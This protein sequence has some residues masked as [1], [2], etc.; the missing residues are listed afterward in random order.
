MQVADS[1]VTGQN[2]FTVNLVHDSLV[3]DTV[4]TAVPVTR[5]P[6]ISHF[7]QS[8]AVLFKIIER[9]TDYSDQ[10]TVFIITLTLM[11]TLIWYFFPER[12]Y[13]LLSK[14][15]SKH[16]AK[17]SDNQFAKPGILL[18]TLYVLTIVSTI[19]FFI[20]FI[21][22][23]LFPDY[24]PHRTFYET[25]ASISVVVFLYFT[26]RVIIIYGAGVLFNTLEPA[27]QQA[28]T[29]FR[30]DLIISFM[31]IPVILLASS[32]SYSS[33]SYAG[34]ILMAGAILLKWVLS[35]KTG[36][37]SSKISLY[38]NILYLCALEIV[39]VIVLIKLIENY[40]IIF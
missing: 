4:V 16:K 3:H 36:L 11:L 24:L 34:V 35:I 15:G 28:R 7:L 33:I 9:P 10:I 22:T 8:E 18:Y 17:Y 1:V 6:A 20:Y 31:L 12:V 23:N 5:Q 19:S 37:K 38:H 13:R 32:I 27:S 14:E 40:R 26:L 25:I 2:P 39:P 30:I 21:I 29:N